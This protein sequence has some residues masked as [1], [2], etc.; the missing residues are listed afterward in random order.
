[1]EVIL[2][3]NLII[4]QKGCH[5]WNAHPWKSM[6]WYTYH[7]IYQVIIFDLLRSLIRG[8]GGHCEVKCHFSAKRRS[9]LKCPPLKTYN[10][11]YIS[12]YL[13]S[14]HFW[15]P[16]VIRGHFERSWR[17]KTRSDVWNWLEYDLSIIR[18]NENNQ[19]DP[20][21][22][23]NVCVK[24]TKRQKTAKIEVISVI[25]SVIDLRPRIF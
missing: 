2:R 19:S 16:A 18:C 20:W 14:H 25:T 15:P 7:C 1:M 5:F 22:F 24:A 8:H 6:I 13:L 17:S 11:I 9:F 10:L 3:P 21:K 23:K 12:P 4:L